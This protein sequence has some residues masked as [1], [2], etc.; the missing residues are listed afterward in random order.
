[1]IQFKRPDMA[2][3]MARVQQMLDLDDAAIAH[4]IGLK[5]QEYR[6]LRD[7]RRKTRGDEYQRID[8]YIQEMVELHDAYDMIFALV[9]DYDLRTTV[10]TIMKYTGVTT[11]G[12]S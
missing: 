3:C 5:A 12:E 4:E 11:T 10:R 2:R 6:D 1:M 8:D 9:E 7:R